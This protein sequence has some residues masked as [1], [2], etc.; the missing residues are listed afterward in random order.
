[1]RKRAR[2]VGFAATAFF[3]AAMAQ[4][5]ETPPPAQEESTTKA[6]AKQEEPKK[7]ES[8]FSQRLFVPRLELGHMQLNLKGNWRKFFHY[9]TAPDGLFVSQFR[10]D[11]GNRGLSTTGF[12]DL[13]TPGE[14][15]HSATGA[16]SFDYGR[17]VADFTN[18]HN[19][20][21]D[22]NPVVL[23]Q[24]EREISDLS[25]KQ[26]FGQDA[27]VVFRYKTDQRD[28]ITSPALRDLHQRTYLTNVSVEGKMA[29]GFGAINYTNW[30]YFD[31]TNVLPD[32]EVR[33]VQLS[34]L[35]DITHDATL[36]GVF[37]HAK[38][39]QDNA[40]NSTIQTAAVNGSWF[41]GPRT[42][43]VGNVTEQ[44]LNLASVENAKAQ[45]RHVANLRW[46][47]RFN[48]WSTQIG[49]RTLQEERVRADAS[50]VDV[51]RWN[52]WDAR[53]TGTIAPNVRLTG[54]AWSQ[55]MDGHVLMTTDDS[56]SLFWREQNYLQAKAETGGIGWNGYLQY[57]GKRQKNP[58]RDVDLKNHNWTVGGF[59]QLSPGLEI[60][61]EHSED[62]YSVNGGPGDA[63]DLGRYL[64]DGSIN[65]FGISWAKDARTQISL[66]YSQFVT[67][68]DNP[69]LLPEG[70]VRGS[71]L[72]TS[73]RYRLP[74]GHE[75]SFSYAPWHFEDHVDSRWGYDAYV[76]RISLSG[77]F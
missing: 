53:I 21:Y 20:S 38:I 30:R 75:V 63:T 49:F 29:Q 74:A 27:A 76:F 47:Q 40:P 12:L 31:R 19:R 22:P 5:Q 33:Q 3:A 68:N 34:Y 73:Y 44:K 57:T 59:K 2:T 43:L 60:Y 4:A 28:Q 15:D 45:A 55:K 10:L 24:N 11:P 41:L 71:F 39:Q 65:V 37:T 70:N 51:P 26:K 50:F 17:F 62:H 58:S 35:R 54:R 1:M 56:R 25:V 52:T 18:Q 8:T 32:T 16:M 46:V 77:R 61:A 42:Q 72:T 64:P 13:R 66:D 67:N 7:E 36:G 23:P 6:D 9:T 48:K 14:W 69:L